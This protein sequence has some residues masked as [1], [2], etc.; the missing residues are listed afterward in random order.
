M[1]QSQSPQ[2]SSSELAPVHKQLLCTGGD[3]KETDRWFS[4]YCFISRYCFMSF[5]ARA[6]EAIASI[7]SAQYSVICHSQKST[8]DSYPLSPFLQS[9][10]SNC[11]SGYSNLTWRN[12]FTLWT[13]WDFCC[14]SRSHWRAALPAFTLVI[15]VHSH[16]WPCWSVF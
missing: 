4:R 5:I 16:L 10:F 12:I 9:C 3:W 2:W 6:R 13:L 1:F 15:W 7:N 14:L 11:C 8:T